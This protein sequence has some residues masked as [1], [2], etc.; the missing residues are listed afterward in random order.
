MVINVD[1]ITQ[2]TIGG[3]TCDK[4]EKTV[5]CNGKLKHTSDYCIKLRAYT[6]DH[7]IDSPCGKAVNDSG[8]LLLS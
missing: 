3:Q 7:Y 8:T 1:R 6:N 4:E 2:Y 5:Y